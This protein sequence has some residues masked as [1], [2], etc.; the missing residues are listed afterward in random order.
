MMSFDKH[1]K[2]FK[3]ISNIVE[4][5]SKEED[6]HGKFGIAIVNILKREH[7]EWFNEELNA[8]IIKACKKAEKAERKVLNWIFE[9]GELDFLPK[10]VIVNFVRNRF[11]NSLNALNINPIFDINEDMLEETLWFDEKIISTKDN[12]F[13]N[14]RTTAYSKKTKS[15]TED[16]LF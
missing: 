16:D 5:T 7:P 3:G 11:N 10:D 4:A 8:Q 9:E 15:I 13:F 1:K 2:M 6:I 14:K 12:D